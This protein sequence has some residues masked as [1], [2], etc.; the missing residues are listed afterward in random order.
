MQGSHRDYRLRYSPEYAKFGVE[1]YA[2]THSRLSLKNREV[3]ARYDNSIL[4]NDYVVT[5][6]M[7][8]FKEEDAVVLYLSDHGQDVFDTSDD[9]FGHSAEHGYDIPMM[10]YPTPVFCEKHGELVNSIKSNTEKEFRTDSLMYTI[11]DIA[12]V[13][14]V[15]CISY[16]Q[17]SLLK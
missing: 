3:V 11:M 10:F 12:G 17:K 15:N 9:F 4:Y 14:T 5:E 6:I 13:E 8:L 2:T 1:D 16:K 7:K